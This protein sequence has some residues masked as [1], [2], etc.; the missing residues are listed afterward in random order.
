[1]CVAPGESH[2]WEAVERLGPAA[3]D[4]QA[5]GSKGGRG[6]DGNGEDKFIK[7]PEQFLESIVEVVTSL[8]SLQMLGWET[9]VTPMPRQIFE[10]LRASATLTGL[11]LQ[12]ASDR[13]NVSECESCIKAHSDFLRAL[14]DPYPLP[15]LPVPFW[16]IS[17]KLQALAVRMEEVDDYADVSDSTESYEAD[18][19]PEDGKMVTLEELCKQWRRY[20]ASDMLHL[21]IARRTIIA[22]AKGGQLRRLNDHVNTQ[23]P[24]AIRALLPHWMQ[25]ED[26]GRCEEF[27]WPRARAA[28]L[29]RPLIAHASLW[30][31]T[32]SA[33][34]V[35]RTLTPQNMQSLQ[36]HFQENGV[37]EVSVIGNPLFNTNDTPTDSVKRYLP[38]LSNDAAGSAV[39]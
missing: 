28:V 35:D 4:W 16:T 25:V 36:A 14:A 5:S 12:F 9:P 3:Y 1:M 31:D 19:V 20:H 29:L 34:T 32:T 10:T 27:S 11:R 39:L 24:L 26:W 38:W 7:T 37:P 17:H 22:A 21:A 6:P 13:G 23:E 15:Q 8:T 18:L 33:P 30:L 2:D